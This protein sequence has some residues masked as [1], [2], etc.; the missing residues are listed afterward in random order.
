MVER[1]RAQPVHD[2]Y[3][4]KID[5]VLT[6]VGSRSFLRGALESLDTRAQVL[7]LGH[8]VPMPIVVRTRRYDQAFYEAITG[9]E[10]RPKDANEAISELYDL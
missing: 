1:W 5:A 9:G 8:A 3:E 6:G 10:S 2:G 4:S 7:L